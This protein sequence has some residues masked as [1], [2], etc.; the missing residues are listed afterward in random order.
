MR[1]N[2]LLAILLAIGI[3]AFG[4]VTTTTAQ[5]ATTGSI[6]VTGDAEVR[7]PPD[8]VAMVFGVETWDKDIRK[9]KTANDDRI[10][11]ILAMTKDYGIDPKYVQTD[12][13]SVD[14][15][16]RNG[17]YT[18]GDFIGYFVRK[19]IV[20]TLKDVSKFEDVYTGALNAGA[21]HV[22]GIEFRTT[23]LRKNRDQARSL[24][25]QAAREKATA[26]AAEL[27]RKVVKAQSIN[28]EYVG[29]YSSYSSRWGGVAM[30]Q[31]V[32]QNSGSSGVPFS[33]ETT[34]APG[35]ISVRARVSVSFVLE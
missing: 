31:N 4:G 21:T 34:F 2:I 26:L 7:V 25:I 15:R 9:A 6:S 23:E 13:I 33:E 1:K 22:Q 19:T 16:Y 27:G 17:N 32:I 10:K 18:D 29:W 11:R 24:A 20:V 14:P 28:E 8:E 35:Q 12:Q 3:L 30:T 5:G